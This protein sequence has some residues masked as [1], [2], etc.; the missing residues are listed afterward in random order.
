MDL[1]TVYRSIVRKH[2]PNA[3]IVA[4]RFHVIRLISQHFVACWKQLDPQGSKSRGFTSLMRRHR[5]N[6]LKPH[7]QVRLNTYLQQ[8]PALEVI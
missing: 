6:H 2:F 7:Q 1:S 3:C 8:C 4:D 5:H